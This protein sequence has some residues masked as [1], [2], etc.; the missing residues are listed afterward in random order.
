MNGLAL[1]VMLFAMGY[2]LLPLYPSAPVDSE[3][4]NLPAIPKSPNSK[5]MPFRLVLNN[6]GTDKV[7]L[8][9]HQPLHTLAVGE[10]VYS[11]ITLKN[12]SDHPVA[13]ELY[14]HLWPGVANMYVSKLSCHCFQRIHLEPFARMQLPISFILHPGLPTRVEQVELHVAVRELPL[15]V[16]STP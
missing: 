1:A 6:E 10:P 13:L 9:H 3:K 14:S 15:A 5:P 2:A 11:F 4:L 7:K 8:L 12:T 16:M